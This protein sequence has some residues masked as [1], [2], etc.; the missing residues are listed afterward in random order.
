M[1]ELSRAQRGS[2]T[3]MSNTDIVLVILG[4]LGGQQR[5]ID[6]EDVAEASWRAVPARFSWPRH[7]EYPDLDAV[8]VTLRA[9]KKNNSLVTG[10]KKRGGMLTADGIS[11]VEQRDASV[12]AFVTEFGNAGRT[13]NRRERGGLDSTLVR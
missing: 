2:D 1:N 3:L 7:Q 8:D 10:A 5:F 9:A 13:D 4:D 11:R 6:V 12:R